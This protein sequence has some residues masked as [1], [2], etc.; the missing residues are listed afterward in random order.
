MGVSSLLPVWTGSEAEL[1]RD[2]LPLLMSRS[3]GVL[4]TEST[5]ACQNLVRPSLTQ[6]DQNLFGPTSPRVAVLGAEA[7]LQR[8]VVFLH[9]FILV[10][11]HQTPLL[12]GSTQGEDLLLGLSVLLVHGYNRT[13]SEQAL[14]ADRCED[15]T[16]LRVFDDLPDGLLQAVG[17][18]HQLL[19]W[20]EDGR[21]RW[22]RARAQRARRRV[23][24]RGR[25]MGGVW[26]TQLLGDGGGGRK[27]RQS[28]R[29]I[30]EGLQERVQLLLQNAALK[31]MEVRHTHTHCDTRVERPA[32]S[33][34]W[35]QIPQNSLGSSRK[36]FR[37][38]P[39]SPSPSRTELWE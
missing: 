25:P 8:H 6:T 3:Q 26:L 17:S 28:L 32:P 20:F 37:S 22:R 14:P 27:S 34:P 15:L 10:L 31:H 7:G 19:P 33:E 2:R 30:T 29:L 35:P 13:G 18:Q 1:L 12:L 4:L 16:F 39:Q 21:C 11:L 38:E 23:V 5:H 24:R 36:L 9:V